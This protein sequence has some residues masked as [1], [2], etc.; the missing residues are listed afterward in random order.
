M[1]PNAAVRVKT[2]EA[3]SLK[4]LENKIN[5]FI[6]DDDNGGIMSIN[7]NTR[8]TG[9]S[10]ALIL[11]IKDAFDVTIE[12]GENEEEYPEDKTDDFDD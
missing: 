10:T 5:K 9:V 2:F 7:Y 4:E 3:G 11:Y 12:D 1:L 8:I 6:E